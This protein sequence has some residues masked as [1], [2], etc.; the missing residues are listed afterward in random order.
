MRWTDFKNI[1]TESDSEDDDY[2]LPSKTMVPAEISKK[3]LTKA[4]GRF[5]SFVSPVIN[6]S[7][8]PGPRFATR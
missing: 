5:V 4:I 1:I 3:A 6:P 7:L 8:G 2:A